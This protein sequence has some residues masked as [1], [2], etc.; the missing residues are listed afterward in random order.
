MSTKN[1]ARTA[2][3]GGR[4]PHAGRDFQLR[5]ATRKTL[6]WHAPDRDTL[7]A[8]ALPGRHKTYRA[9]NDKLAAPARWLASHV[10]RPWDHVRGEMFARF[11]TRTTAGRHI[12]F[13]HLLRW[14]QDGTNDNRGWV[15]FVVDRHGLLRNAPPHRRRPW[16][17]AAMPRPRP[18]LD[19]W[20]G[21]RRVASRGDV[22]FWFIP[23]SAGFYRQHHRLLEEEAV[24]W[25]A[26]PVWYRQQRHPDAPPPAT[27]E[28]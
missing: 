1:L 27:V 2:I 17:S 23:T 19:A 16:S 21:D 4:C 6:G 25:R 3:E 5:M 28:T 18:D 12:V 22:L 8:L 10:G 14:V 26:L 24:R 15:R 13:D 11:D 20:L 7:D 9:F